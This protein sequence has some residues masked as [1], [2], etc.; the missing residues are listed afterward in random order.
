M[1]YLHRRISSYL[2]PVTMSAKHRL[3]DLNVE[4]SDP[5]RYSA[6]SSSNKIVFSRSLAKGWYL[7]DVH[8]ESNNFSNSKIYLGRAG[9]FNEGD[10]IFLP[11]GR[12]KRVKRVF[13]VDHSLTKIGFRPVEKKCSFTIRSFS[14]VALAPYRAKQL[15][16][17][18]LSSLG[19]GNKI[20]LDTKRLLSDYAECF[21][22]E[23]VSY[24]NWIEAIEPKLVS[25][26]IQQGPKL[27]IVMPV[28]NPNITYLKEAIDSVL[29]QSYKNWELCIADD[30]S[31]NEEVS[32]FLKGLEIKDPRTKVCIR[33]RNGHISEASNSA[34]NLV[35]GEYTILMDHDDLLSANALNE[36]AL[37]IQNNPDVKII[38]SDEDKIDESGRRFEPHF[39][40]QFN[41]ELLLNQNYISHLGC[42]STS[43]IKMVGGFRKGYEGSQDYDLLLRC[44][45]KI[46]TKNQIIHIPKVL[47]HWRA[48]KGSTAF[49]AAEKSYTNDAG[50]RALQGYIKAVEPSAQVQNGCL[51]NT[52]RLSRTI[53]GEPEVEIIIPTR[54]R[55]EILRPCID[56]ILEKTSYKNYVIT[57]VDN[58]SI[59][60]ETLA[61][62]SVIVESP[63]VKVLKVSGEFN[64]SKLN[65]AAV[66]Q[67]SSDFIVLLN[68]DIEVITSEWLS[69][70]LVLAQT[71]DAGCIGAKLFYTDGRVQHAGVTLG[72][73]G[74]AGHTHKYFPKSSPGYFSRLHLSHEVSAVTAACM[75]IRRD[76][77][78]QAGGLDEAN[79]AVAFNDIDLCLKV[80]SLGLKNLWTPHAEL[81]HHES[82]SRGNEDT[83]QKR[84]RFKMES[85]FMKEKW[86]SLLLSDPFYSP[87]LTLSSE[88]FSIR[89]E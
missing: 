42:Y 31:T 58:D 83:P 50:L 24:K 57:I 71:K 28:Y 60:K 3:Y 10:I 44:L 9:N 65:N 62:F 86:G 47:Y 39:K 33:T 75:L 32:N 35:T 41:H 53:V 70:M 88:D 23:S 48:T 51:P 36:I 17:K 38:Y 1:K 18:K 49:E 6:Y 76:I 26:K 81:Y 56:S 89:S 52:Y 27:S 22:G 30:C 34:I 37:E 29:C 5:I 2:S 20:R 79:L 66:N 40:C 77:Y 21:Y 61:Y 11:T 87:N 74:V 64:F 12:G 7:A 80:R 45:Q 46:D 19:L 15:I 68:N 72:I 59:K 73:G 16:F 78:N 13:Y 25:N 85:N 54:D 43:L 82:A 8:I 4:G 63:R 14:I 84:N 67:S 69:E 55:L